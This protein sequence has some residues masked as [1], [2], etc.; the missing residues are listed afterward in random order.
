VHLESTAGWGEAKNAS[1]S[2]IQAAV[3]LGVNSVESIV[4]KVSFD[5]N[6]TCL[7]VETADGNALT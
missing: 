3:D 5:Q 1:R 4:S 6:G 7:G 2:V